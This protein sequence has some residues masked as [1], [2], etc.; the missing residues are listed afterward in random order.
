[1]LTKELLYLSDADVKTT[2]DLDMK[3]HFPSLYRLCPMPLILPLQE[4]LTVVMPASS[5]LKNAHHPFKSNAPTFHGQFFVMAN[6]LELTDVL[7]GAEFQEEISVM[8]SLVKPKRVTVRGSDG[9][10]YSFLCKPK[11][12]LRK[13]ARLMDFFAMINKLLK[14]DSESRRRRLRVYSTYC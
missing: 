4:S 14:A 2:G 3:K 11:D 10:L 7:H 8:P 6:N 1:M 5:S 13:D 9:G 12:D